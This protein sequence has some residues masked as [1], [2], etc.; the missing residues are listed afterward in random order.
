MEETTLAEAAGALPAISGADTAWMIAACALVLLMT[1]AWS[2]SLSL[3]DWAAT[4]PPRKEAREQ[5]RT[6]V[7]ASMGQGWAGFAASGCS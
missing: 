3:T 2:G 7:R 5:A 1:P 4:A 6:Q